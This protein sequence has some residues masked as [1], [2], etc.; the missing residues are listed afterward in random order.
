[1]C[2]KN[3]VRLSFWGLNDIFDFMMRNIIRLES[4]EIEN[5]KNVNNGRLSFLGA[6]SI[7]ECLAKENYSNLKS[8]IMGIYGQNGSGKT[9]V[10]DALHFLKKMLLGVVLDS[11]TGNYVN[12]KSKTLKCSFDFFLFCENSNKFYIT[13]SFSIAKYAIGKNGSSFYIKSESLKFGGIVENKKLPPKKI[14]EY[15]LDKSSSPFL[16]LEN[17]SHFKKTIPEEQKKLEA[18]LLLSKEMRKSFIFSMDN[19]INLIKGFNNIPNVNDILKSLK[20]YGQCFLF[21][22]RNDFSSKNMEGREFHLSYTKDLDNDRR[23]VAELLYQ[24]STKALPIQ[25]KDFDLIKKILENLNVVIKTLIPDMFLKL[26]EIETTINEKGEKVHNVL[27]CTERKGT[28]V[29]LKYESDGIKKIVAILGILI[30]MYNN[31][32]VALAVDELDSGVFE[33]LLGELVKIFEETGKGQLI[34]TSHNL[35]PLELLNYKSLFFTTTNE[36]NRYIQLNSIKTN[37]NVRDVY[38]NAVQLGGQKEELYE[39]VDSYKI[40]SALHN[41]AKLEKES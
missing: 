41:A 39:M 21:V 15:D 6:K 16:T 18:F 17:L 35:R 29:P 34:F 11:D 9:A 10:I 8:D 24:Y 23:L 27:L 37:N 12:D 3:K 7:S 32:S 25:D 26:D 2:Q 19:L 38:Y 13:Y 36:N 4:I 22:F 5:L 14:I 31:P 28:I 20:R 40:R 33:Y 1:M 30:N